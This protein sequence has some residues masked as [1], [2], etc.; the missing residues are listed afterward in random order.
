MKRPW[1]CI[2]QHSLHN[3][4]DYYGNYVSIKYKT[5]EREGLDLSS[6]LL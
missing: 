6:Q 3:K 4:L 2:A 1:Y 5:L